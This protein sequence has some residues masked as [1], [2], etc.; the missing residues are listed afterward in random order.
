MSIDAQQ[1][2]Y[3]AKAIVPSGPG[4]LDQRVRLVAI[5]MARVRAARVVKAITGTSP[6]GRFSPIAR[7]TRMS[8][9]RPYRMGSVARLRRR[10][11][12]GSRGREARAA[13]R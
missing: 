13:R 7:R 11:G 1:S 5:A 4:T 8:T 12:S 2:R 9:E 10:V 6:A 3:W